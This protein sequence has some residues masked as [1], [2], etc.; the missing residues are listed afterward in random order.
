MV[1]LLL[2]HACDPLSLSLHT[3]TSFPASMGVKTSPYLFGAGVCF[4]MQGNFAH[5][6]LPHRLKGKHTL[7][8]LQATICSPQSKLSGAINTAI[9]T[10]KQWLNG[11]P[12]GQNGI[13]STTYPSML[14]SKTSK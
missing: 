11:F 9:P 10:I 1:C 14:G 8:K 4:L 13:W 6:L 12:C 5:A 3:I 2:L 7:R